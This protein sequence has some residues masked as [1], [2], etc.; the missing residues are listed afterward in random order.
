MFCFY[1]YNKVLKTN[2]NCPTP[3]IAPVVLAK[4]FD[5]PAPLYYTNDYSMLSPATLM[6]LLLLPA[7][8]MMKSRTIQVMLL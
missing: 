5:V 7:W 8:I 4:T 3:S 1:I 6:A 2:H